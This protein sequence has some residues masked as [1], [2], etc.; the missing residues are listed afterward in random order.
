MMVVVVNEVLQGGWL[1]FLTCVDFDESAF[2]SEH[3]RKRDVKGAAASILHN[4]EKERKEA[5]E[6]AAAAAAAGMDISTEEAENRSK[7][8]DVEK[9]QKQKITGMAEEE[10]ARFF[11]RCLQPRRGTGSRRSS[12]RKTP[13]SSSQDPDKKSRRDVSETQVVDQQQ[14]RV[15]STVWDTSGVAASNGVLAWHRATS[16]TNSSHQW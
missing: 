2:D 7:K 16:R 11:G 12:R 14:N 9:E 1:E 13:T 8:G 5:A 3:E 15:Q 4:K 6:H 10:A